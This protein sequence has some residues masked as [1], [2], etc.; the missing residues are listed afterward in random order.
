MPADARVYFITIGQLIA[1]ELSLVDG[2]QIGNAI[3]ETHIQ[4]ELKG[5]YKDHMTHAHES[6][7]AVNT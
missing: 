4:D 3:I 1:I 7:I 5:T 2:Q 6:H